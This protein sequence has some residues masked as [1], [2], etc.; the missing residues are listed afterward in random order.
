MPQ[1]TRQGQSDYTFFK[2]HRFAPILAQ[3]LRISKAPQIARF[4]YYH[5]DLNSGSGYNDQAAV[6]G[7]PLNFLS[8][9]VR[10]DRPNFYAFFVDKERSYIQTLITRPEVEANSERVYAYPYDNRE[11]LPVVDAFI[12]QRE[13]HP[14][15]AVG[16][17]LIDPNGWHGGVPWD[18]LRVFCQT[19][20]RIDV[21]MNLNVRSFWL[22][23]SHIQRATRGWET[24]PLRAVSNFPSWFHRDHWMLTDLCRMQS[25]TWVQLVGRSMQT[26]TP[27]YRSLGFYDLYSE[28][29]RDIVAR[30]E[31]AASS[32]PVELPLLSH[33]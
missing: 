23:R 2:E 14:H 18:E 28:H 30:I 13:R 1:S 10:N 20:R 17:I 26:N 16:S 15:F 24:K 6:A 31:T 32:G 11:I 9:V 22:E 27:D 12:A 29:G 5:V 4:A 33:L 3:S 7:S 21:L 25:N 8:A 19:H